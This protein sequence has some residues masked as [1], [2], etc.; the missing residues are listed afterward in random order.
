M[1]RT[2]N[3]GISNADFGNIA[4]KGDAQ[5]LPVKLAAKKEPAPKP[6]KKGSWLETFLKPIITFIYGLYD[7]LSGLSKMLGL[8]FGKK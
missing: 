4:E 5:V 1:I 8:F 2:V 6:K 7:F 3:Q